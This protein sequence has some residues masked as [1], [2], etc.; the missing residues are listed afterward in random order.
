[1]F[2]SNL[3]PVLLDTFPTLRVQPLHVWKT[4]N[5]DSRSFLGKTWNAKFAALYIYLFAISRARPGKKLGS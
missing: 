3:I 1:M 4:P 2:Q 5:F